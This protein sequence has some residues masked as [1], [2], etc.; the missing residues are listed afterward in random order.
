MTPITKIPLK[1][2][3]DAELE[4]LKDSAATQ[5]ALDYYLKPSVT[6][7]CNEQKVFNVSDDVGY[8]EAL[9]HASDLM[10][11]ALTTLMEA[12]RVCKALI[13]TSSGAWRT[14]LKWPKTWSTRPSTS[15]KHLHAEVGRRSKAMKLHTRA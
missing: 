1:I 9:L 4:A 14:S 12:R 6:Q 10:R 15:K 13:W 3:A 5:R 2:E 7:R 8:E 11:F